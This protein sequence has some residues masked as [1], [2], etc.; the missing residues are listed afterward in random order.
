MIL[1]SIY[2]GTKS[3]QKIYHN[4]G[5][6]SFYKPIAFQVVEDGKLIIIGALTVNNLPDGLYLDCTSDWVYPVLRGNTLT[7]EQ[8]LSATLTGNTLE[9]T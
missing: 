5:E 4:G 2:K 3:I 6:I 7:V 8:V 9:V 1:K